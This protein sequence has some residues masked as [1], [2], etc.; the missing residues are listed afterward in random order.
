[1][2]YPNCLNQRFGHNYVSG[3]CLNCRGFQNQVKKIKIEI[4]Q[5]KN[6]SGSA[7]AFLVSQ[8][9]EEIN[10]SRG[11]YPPLT[12]ARLASLLAPLKTMEDLRWFYDACW[13]ED[14]ITRKKFF[15]P[16]YFWFSLKK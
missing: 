9:L 5:K 8:F 16:K 10:K 14:K 11:S 2:N 1:M 3:I 4:P 7:R 15:N 13:Q 6:K 12:P